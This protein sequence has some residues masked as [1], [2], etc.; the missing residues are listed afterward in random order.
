MCSAEMANVKPCHTQSLTD[1]VLHLS[2][3][4]YHTESELDNVIFIVLP[5]LKA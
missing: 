4:S 3:A 5:H 2:E 1:D